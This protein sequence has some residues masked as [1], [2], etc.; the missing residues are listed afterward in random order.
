MSYKFLAKVVKAIEML[1]FFLR[2]YSYF[3]L[4]KFWFRKLGQRC[5]F[6]GFP[7]FGYAFRDICLGDNC[8]LGKDIFFN[9]GPDSF[10]NIGSNVG[11][12]DYIY[13]SSVYGITIGNNTR[14]G[15]FVSIRDNDHQ[16]SQADIPIRLQ[17][18]TGKPIKIGSD[19][20]IGRGVYIGKG[21]EIGDGAV[22]GANSVVTKYIPPYAVAVGVPA[23]IIKYRTK[24]KLEVN[25]L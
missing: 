14:I 24:E 23:K 18:F 20:W 11:L 3:L 16:F 2:A 22:I 17:G 25:S 5:Q 9:C 21:I 15:E 13:I 8:I 4:P 19:V 1:V 10:I 7:R 12:N 6:K